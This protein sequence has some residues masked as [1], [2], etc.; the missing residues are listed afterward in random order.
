V[1]Q[2]DRQQRT[3]FLTAQLDR[4]IAGEDLKRTQNSIGPRS[5]CSR[6]GYHRFAAALQPPLLTVRAN[7]R[8]A[9]P[10]EPL[11]VTPKR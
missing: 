11:D 5:R 8:S 4:A 1:H 3:L 2:Q 6:Q 7:Q 9:S 10:P